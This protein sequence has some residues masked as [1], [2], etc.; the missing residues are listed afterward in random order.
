[1]TR[2]VGI[3]DNIKSYSIVLSLLEA[4]GAQTRAQGEVIL[5]LENQVQL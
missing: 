2:T 3:E 4:P 1:M 5:D